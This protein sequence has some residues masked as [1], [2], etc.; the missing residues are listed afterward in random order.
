MLVSMLDQKLVETLPN[1]TSLVK[2]QNYGDNYFKKIEFLGP[3][4][5]NPKKGLVRVGAAVTNEDF[6]RWC[7]KDG[8]WTLPLNVIMVE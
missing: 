5:K 3:D 2:D 6:R 7:M 4:E 8:R 1:C